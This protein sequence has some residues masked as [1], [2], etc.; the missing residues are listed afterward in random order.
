MKQQIMSHYTCS[1]CHLSNK[2]YT[3]TDDELAIAGKQ[4]VSVN[5][6]LAHEK[7]K[8]L[9][10]NAMCVVYHVYIFLKFFNGL[11]V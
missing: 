3:L 7:R 5:T 9:L 2:H 4:V 10:I 6:S 1:D 11:T 8:W